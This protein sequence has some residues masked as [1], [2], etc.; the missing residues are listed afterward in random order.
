VRDRNRAAIKAKSA[1]ITGSMIRDL[2]TMDRGTSESTEVQ[3]EDIRGKSQRCE[4]HQVFGTDREKV[5]WN[6]QGI[7]IYRS[8]WWWQP[9]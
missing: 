4:H 3:H 1:E 8:N 6:D 9:D 7:A 5:M 2:I